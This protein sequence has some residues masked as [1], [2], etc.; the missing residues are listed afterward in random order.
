MPGRPSW[1]LL[2]ACRSCFSRLTSLPFRL[3]KFTT[4]T[5]RPRDVRI[6]A[7]G[8]L[9][10]P[11]HPPASPPPGHPQQGHQH[12]GGY[13]HSARIQRAM[14][15]WKG[16]LVCKEPGLPFAGTW[17]LLFAGKNIHF[18]INH[19]GLAP[20]SA[21]CSAGLCSRSEQ[22]P[23]TSGCLRW[24]LLAWWQLFAWWQHPS[25]CWL[26]LGGVGALLV[27]PDTSLVLV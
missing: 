8:A 16:S 27:P 24:Q 6:P 2:W 9:Q 25:P 22:P 23:S 10:I 1:A 18:P 12:L 15:G 5:V 13:R 3:I 7:R 11:T 21:W 17:P 26:G 14:W 19:S 20:C 4:R